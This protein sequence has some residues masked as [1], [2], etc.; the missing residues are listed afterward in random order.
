MD[1]AL[2]LLELLAASDDGLTLREL[3]H[4][5]ALKA[6]TVHNLLRTLSARG[7]VAKRSSPIRYAV[8]PALSALARRASRDALYAQVPDVLRRLAARFPQARVSWTCCAAG[9]LA[10]RLRIVPGAPGVVEHPT[11]GTMSP[12]ASASGLAFQ[13]FADAESVAEFRRK[14][15]F[16]EQGA[17][18]WQSPE[19]LEQALDGFRKAGV[20]NIA[21]RGEGLRKLAAPVY[22]ADG[23][24]A[25]CLGL[26]LPAGDNDG[27]E[28][29]AQLREAA[30]S[31]GS[32][33]DRRRT[34]GRT[35]N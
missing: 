11:G 22:G 35:C 6:P 2:D 4:R 30:A 34:E 10:M 21:L 26:A 17:I 3:A 8:G 33:N 1:R 24:F 32:S 29:A 14:H 5:S 12:Y 9:E 27:A 20:V 28:A 15:P 16:W 25:A 7:Y 18:L 13:A 23:E 31:L 19:S